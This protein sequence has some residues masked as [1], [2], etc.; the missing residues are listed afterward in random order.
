MAKKPVPSKKQA[1]SSTRSRHAAWVRN[2][3]ENLKNLVVLDKCSETGETKLRHFASPSGKYRGRQVFD[4]KQKG[5][6]PIREIEA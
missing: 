1:V 5:T 2:Q 6:D 4:V 3:R